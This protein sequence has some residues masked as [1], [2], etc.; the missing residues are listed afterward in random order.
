[1]ACSDIVAADDWEPKPKPS[2]VERMF[3]PGTRLDQRYVRSTR[4]ADPPHEDDDDISETMTVE[5]WTGSSWEQAWTG[6]VAESRYVGD[7]NDPPM[8]APLEVEIWPTPAGDRAALIVSNDYTDPG[9]GHYMDRVIWID[10]PRGTQALPQPSTASPSWQGESI[11]SIDSDPEYPDRAASER[12]SSIG[13]RLH[14][15]RPGA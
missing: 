7:S 6:H 2:S 12:E 15:V 9:I 13:L 10:L 4:R 5:L 3:T 1:M 8:D 14:R 11:P